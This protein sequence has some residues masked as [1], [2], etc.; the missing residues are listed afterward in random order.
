MCDIEHSRHRSPVNFFTNLI[1]GLIRY[2]YFEKKPSIKFSDKDRKILL[3]NIQTI[4]NTG[5]LAV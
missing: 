5:M 2:T 4:D 1:A 3:S